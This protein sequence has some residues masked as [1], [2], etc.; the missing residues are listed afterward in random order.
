MRASECQRGDRSS[1]AN[2]KKY[3][4]VATCMVL[5]LVIIQ[6]F[7]PRHKNVVEKLLDD[8]KADR[9]CSSGMK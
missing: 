1:Q 9:G 4:D 5:M 7:P 2:E 8:F 6:L 3:S